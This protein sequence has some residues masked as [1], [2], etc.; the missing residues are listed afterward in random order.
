MRYHDAMANPLRS[1]LGRLGAL[2][3]AQRLRTWPRRLA[4]FLWAYRHLDLARKL[5]VSGAAAVFLVAGVL[6]TTTYFSAEDSL[7]TQM[8]RQVHGELKVFE[9]L[10]T[11][12]AM[13]MP[14]ELESVTAQAACE[15]MVT[16]M[17]GFSAVFVGEQVLAAAGLPGAA[18]MR[19]VGYP[20]QE[21]R[22]SFLTMRLGQETYLVALHP[23]LDEQGRA[24]GSLARGVPEKQISDMLQKHAW[25]IFS[26][27]GTAMLLALVALAWLTHDI[28]APLRS[29]ARASRSLI[30]EDAPPHPLPERVGQDE[31]GRLATDFKAIAERLAAQQT[32]L[33]EKDRLRGQLL[34]KVITAQEDERRRIS[35]ELHDQTGQSL[36][37]L[38]VGLKVLDRAKSL[39]E[40]RDR[41]GHLKELVHAT[42]DEVHRISV[43]LRPAMLDDLGLIAALR[44]SAND[45]ETAHGI[46]V[47]FHTTHLEGR[48]PALVESPIYRVVQEAL[49]N[50]A[51]YAGARHV[52]IALER[53]DARIVATVEDDGRGFDAAAVLTAR[54]RENLGLMGMQER[55]GLLGGTF[56]L[57]SAPGEGTR[58]RFTIPL[59]QLGD[60]IHAPDSHPHLG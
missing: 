23:L 7:R 45:F 54:N 8:H 3:W 44:A 51:K 57:D 19:L 13:A 27:A 32:A 11:S 6:C 10:Y 55:I 59:E 36:T 4:A 52:R 9:R 49:T 17:G 46:K 24:L 26:V 37:G 48:L 53:T 28:A 21:P 34:D 43:E 22:D 5:L 16:L 38:L 42:L 40:V 35:R 20:H 2:P 30:D 25:G 14:M 15:E 60:P 58:I 29:L 12:R 39:D 1:W 50:V 41:L 47:E 56:L 33:E 31:V 18:D